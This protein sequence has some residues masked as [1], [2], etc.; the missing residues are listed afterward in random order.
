[1][2]QKFLAMV[3]TFLWISRPF[4]AGLAKVQIRSVDNSFALRL[5]RKVSF[6]AHGEAWR[7]HETICRIVALPSVDG[8][9]RGPHPSL[10]ERTVW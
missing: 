9:R 3:Q 1:M 10:K 8:S 6:S 7:Q 2:V 5:L 4:G